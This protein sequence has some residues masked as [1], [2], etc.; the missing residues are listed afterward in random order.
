MEKLL[1]PFGAGPKVSGT[2]ISE[3]RAVTHRNPDGWVGNNNPRSASFESGP[4]QAP[5]LDVDTEAHSDIRSPTGLVCGDRPK[6][7][8]LSYLASA[9]TISSVRL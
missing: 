3:K 9:Q 2:Q 7:R 1:F 4:A 8:I 5:V 6:G